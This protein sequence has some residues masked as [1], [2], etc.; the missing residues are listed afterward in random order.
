ME[1]SV[2]LQGLPPQIAHR[3][4]ATVKREDAAAYAM[5][6]LEQLKLKRFYDAI[7]VP[8][9]NTEYTR[10]TMCLSEGQRREAYRTYGQLCFADPDVAR[11]LLKRHEEYR[12]KD[13]GTR[14]QSGFTGRG[15]TAATERD[16]VSRSNAKPN[17][18]G[19]RA[20]GHRPALLIARR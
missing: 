14:I 4:I 11:F 6:V 20:A 9:M 18:E 17:N 2:N 7:A 3:V 5:G 12:V 13:V 15:Y 19:E 8:G 16:S 10:Q 1:L